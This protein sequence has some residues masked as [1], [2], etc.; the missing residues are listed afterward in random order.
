MN[1]VVF[2]TDGPVLPVCMQFYSKYYLQVCSDV[3][4]R[5]ACVGYCNDIAAECVNQCSGNRNC[6]AFCSS[7]EESCINSCP[8]HGPCLAGCFDCASLFC[9]CANQELNADFIACET[10]YTSIY[11]DCVSGCGTDLACNGVCSR[12]FDNHLKSCPCQENCPS[13]CPCPVYQCIA[14][15]NTST[16]EILSTSTAKLT[17][18]VVTTQSTNQ[19]HLSNNIFAIWDNSLHDGA[20]LTNTNGEQVDVRINFNSDTSAWTLCS[21]MYQNEIY[22]LGWVSLSSLS[23]QNCM[24]CMKPK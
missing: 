3:D 21:V 8:C 13:G 17:T 11:I 18:S 22:F 7:N 23:K 10:R 20:L 15:E 24:N 9:Q 16:T 14:H 5:D 19:G 12:E 2:F 6:L 1:A 4:L